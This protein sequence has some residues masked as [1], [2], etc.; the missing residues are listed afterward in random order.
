LETDV[1]VDDITLAAALVR[2]VHAESLG[3]RRACGE[4]LLRSIGGVALVHR[5][6]ENTW[7]PSIDKV[8]V[9]GQSGSITV[10][11]N[12][13]VLVG[14]TVRLIICRE[15]KVLQEHRRVLDRVARRTVE[16]V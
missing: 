16:P 5:S 14:S 15:I 7:I 8:G 9:H 3:K 12:P 1:L 6:L 10:R 11:Q 4:I 2:V 13:V